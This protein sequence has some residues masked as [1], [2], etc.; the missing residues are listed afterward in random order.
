MLSVNSNLSALSAQG[1][2]STNSRGLARVIEQLSTGKRINSSADDVAG[3]AISTRLTSQI[4][5]LN[6]AI[7]N[8][9]DAIS[10]IQTAD[11]A[12]ESITNILQRMRELSIQY[13]NDT[14]NSNDRTYIRAEILSLKK[15]IVRISS[16]TAWNGAPLFDATKILNFQVGPSDSNGQN[17]STI[18]PNLDRII[19]EPISI[20]AGSGFSSITSVFTPNSDGSYT[21]VQLRGDTDSYN[22]AI[23]DINKDGNLDIVTSSNVFLGDGEGNFTKSANLGGGNDVYTAD[24]NSDGYPD[25]LTSPGNATLHLNLGD[26][27]FGPAQI[28]STGSF[29]A[30]ATFADIN[31]DGKQDI[32]TLDFWDTKVSIFLGDG[33]G[34][35][36]F[37]QSVPVG[38][39][40]GYVRITDINND[41]I[42]DIVSENQAGIALTYTL[43]KADGSFQAPQ[44]LGGYYG[45]G[46]EVGDI[47]ND[48]LSDIVTAIAGLNVI[49]IHK[50]MGSGNFVTTIY[51]SFGS[52]PHKVALTDLNGDGAVDLIVG[53]EFSKSVSISHNDGT[54]SF[55]FQQNLTS[56]HPLNGVV[57]GIFDKSK[58]PNLGDIDD[59]IKVTNSTR[60]NFG[61]TISRIQFTVDNLS[62][63]SLNAQ[64]SRSRIEDTD[65]SAATTELAKRNIIQQAAQA[66]LAQANQQPQA[67]LQLLKSTA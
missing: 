11:S 55:T 35:F 43:G 38:G 12:A 56:D 4:R 33:T 32:I 67:I 47:N 23:A 48:S 8:G 14:N 53:N 9:N 18:I 62:N 21:E 17:I 20:V 37:N 54:G 24:V 7:R 28:Y 61:A 49:S 30:G 50:N 41:E 5:A 57:A 26:G 59:A 25:I 44:S 31:K 22:S 60:A 58:L 66:M 42:N 64:A 1:T 10:M 40:P 65:Y 6:Q 63:T 45:Y 52:W 16:N 36:N 39:P 19:K 3:M 29:A 46:L 15:E 27:T 2:M 34:S 13:G 51:P